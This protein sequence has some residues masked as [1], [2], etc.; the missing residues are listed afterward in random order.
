VSEAGAPPSLAE[1]LAWTGLEL[2]DRR[3][4]AVGRVS[5][6]YADAESGQPV[7]LVVSVGRRRR[8][9]SVV[10]P[11]RECAAMPARAWAAEERE[12]LLGSHSVDPGRPLLREHEIVICE[13]YGIG[14]PVGRHAEVVDRP[15]GVVTAQPA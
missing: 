9:K 11:V 6:V 3:G 10:V 1:A 14:A 7:W 13:H 15:E 5:G 2:D 8:T 12:A 4:E